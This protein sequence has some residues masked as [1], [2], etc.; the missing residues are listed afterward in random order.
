MFL[1]HL[2]AM[3]YNRREVIESYDFLCQNCVHALRV[4]GGIFFIYFLQVEVTW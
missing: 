3:P 2:Q 1:F 4:I